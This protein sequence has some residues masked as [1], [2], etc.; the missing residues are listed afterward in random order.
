MHAMKIIVSLNFV[1]LL[2]FQREKMENLKQ[3]LESELR[4]LIKTRSEV[5]QME[6]NMVE[7][8]KNKSYYNQQPVRNVYLRL[9]YEFIL[10]TLLQPATCR[11]NLSMFILQLYS[12]KLQYYN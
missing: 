9:S 5:K 2:K 7:R 8:K 1:A 6:N 11:W 4:K 3:D 10:I 12:I